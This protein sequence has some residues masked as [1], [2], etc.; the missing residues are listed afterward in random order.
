[1][2]ITRSPVGRVIGY[3]STG[4]GLGHWMKER[5]TAL[6]LVPLGIWFVVSAVSLSGAGYDDVRNWLASPWNA[7]LMILT[8]ALSFWH[9]QLG[10]QVVIEDY[11]HGGIAKPAALLANVFILGL[12]GTACVVAVLKVSFGS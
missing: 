11:V 9:A 12:L 7:T 10:I 4:E 5:V 2:T 3:G 1:M 6:A 8:V